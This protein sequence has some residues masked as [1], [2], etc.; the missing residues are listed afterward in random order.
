MN[1]SCYVVDDEYHSV[2]ILKAYIEKTPGL[3]L[4]GSATNPLTGLNEVASADPPGITFLDV[5]MPELS[6]LE[7]AGMASLYTKIIFTTSYPEYALQAFEKDAVDYLLK[8]ISYERFLKAVNKVKKAILEKTGSGQPDAG[9]FFIKTDLKGK[10]QKID[11]PD[12]VYVEAALNY[13][14]LHC[15]SGKYM[16]YLTMEE[17]GDRLPKNR[18]LRTHHSFIVNLDRIRTLEHGQLTLED[19]TILPLGRSYKESLLALM[20]ALLLESRRKS[21]S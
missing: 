2:E 13:I 6:G 8:P 5:D 17:I 18:F 12:I 7:F 1:L 15:R 14:R 4:K 21:G 3:E 16:A 11:I 19:Q 20:R 9:Y 10:L